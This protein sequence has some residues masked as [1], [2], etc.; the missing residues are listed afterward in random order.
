MRARDVLFSGFFVGCVVWDIWACPYHKE[1]NFGSTKM[2]ICLQG[3]PY[4]EGFESCGTK[5]GVRLR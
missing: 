4:S 5:R 3:T 1:V 2:C